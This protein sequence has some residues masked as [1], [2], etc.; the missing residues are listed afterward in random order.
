MGHSVTGGLPSSATWRRALELLEERPDA[1][2][3]VGAR[4]TEAADRRLREFANEPALAD[5]FWIL[6]RLAWASRG[7][8][9]AE[10][11]EALGLDVPPATAMVSFVG[12]VET[13]FVS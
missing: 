12:I 3:A 7:D 5:A 6:T 9:F 1:V 2:E 13:V 8:R 4:L 11:F 10:T